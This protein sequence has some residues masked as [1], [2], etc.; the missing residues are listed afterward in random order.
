MPVKSFIAMDALQKLL[1]APLPERLYH[2]TT[3]SGLTG[4]VKDR[5]IWAT[6][7]HYQ[8][9]DSELVLALDLAKEVAAE[10]GVAPESRRV[11]EFADQ[12]AT[13]AH[14]YVASFTAA[15]DVLSQW[16]GY[17][18][19]GNGYALG[20]SPQALRKAASNSRE[21]PWLLGKVCYDDAEQR[22]I[23]RAWVE[24]AVREFETEVWDEG[25]IF[26]P[27]GSQLLNHYLRHGPLLKHKAFEQEEEWRLV[28]PAEAQEVIIEQQFE[29]AVDYREGTYSLIPYVKL[30]LGPPGNW[31]LEN[32]CVSPGLHKERRRQT[33]ERWLH[34]KD[35]HVPVLASA[36]PIR[37]EGV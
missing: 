19:A 12:Q 9:D 6:D 22:T 32:I 35:E 8:N 25:P 17:G 21:R 16:R 15:S 20:L 5:E 24:A 28:S 31:G 14:V 34:S 1:D 11:L 3:P 26:P 2:Y 23:V 33:A 30:P 7:I 37:M 13:M 29:Y 27:G 36:I 4:I 18:G 10:L